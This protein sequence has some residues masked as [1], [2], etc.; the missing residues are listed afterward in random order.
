MTEIQVSRTPHTLYSAREKFIGFLVFGNLAVLGFSA[1]LMIFVLLFATE[2]LSKMAFF[3]PLVLMSVSYILAVIFGIL[4]LSRRWWLVPVVLMYVI[5]FYGNS[6][7]LER[8]K[9]D[10]LVFCAEL[11]A[12]PDCAWSDREDA[13]VC[14]D[15]ITYSDM[16]PQYPEGEGAP[17][18]IVGNSKIKEDTALQKMRSLSCD[19]DWGMVWDDVHGLYGGMKVEICGA[20]IELTVVKNGTTKYQ[21]TLLPDEQT[22]LYELAGRAEK[23]VSQTKLPDVLPPDFS[24]VTMYV[25][26][27]GD[28]ILRRFPFNDQPREVKVLYD[29]LQNVNE[30]LKAR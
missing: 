12:D 2:P 1:P 17:A 30:R 27:G 20:R 10:A 3:D 15:N 7:D 16:C 21:G 13:F 24:V 4:A 26:Q 23:S 22:L 28:G 29:A 18:S 11:R 14:E 25:E 6:M 5:F 9:Q 19:A 8:S